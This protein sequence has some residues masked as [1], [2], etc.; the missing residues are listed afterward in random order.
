MVVLDR[1]RIANAVLAIGCRARFDGD[2]LMVS[3]TLEDGTIADLS[4]ELGPGRQYS[5][6]EFYVDLAECPRLRGLA[7][8]GPNGKMCSLDPV[9][10]CPNPERP[11]DALV[12]VLGLVIA[13]LNDSIMGRNCEDYQDEITAYWAAECSGGRAYAFD[14]PPVGTS[15]IFGAYSKGPTGALCL[16]TSQKRA[17]DFA[18]R[19][20]QSKVDAEDAFPCLLLDLSLPVQYPFPQTVSEWDAEIARSGKRASREYRNFVA[21]CTRSKAATIVLSSPAHGGRALLCFTQD[22]IESSDGFRKGEKLFEHAVSNTGYGDQR[23]VKRWAES[24]SQERLFSR[25][26][27]GAPMEGTYAIVGCGSLG[28]HL[29]RA[30]ADA[31]ASSFTVVDNDYIDAENVARHVC[32]FESVGMEKSSALKR[33]LESGNPNVTCTEYHGDVNA[34]VEERP[35]TFAGASAIF[36]TV[37]DMPTEYHMVKALMAGRIPRPLIIMW[38]EPYMLAA[39]AIVLNRPQ[40]VF[41]DLFDDEYRFTRSVVSNSDELF[42]REPGCQTTYMPYA[43]LDVQSFVIE[44]LKRWRSLTAD[45]R[46][47]Y[48]FTWVGCLSGANDVGAVVSAGHIETVDYTC[49]VERI[50]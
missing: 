10:N 38:L 34:I 40:E 13:N 4:C 19:L 1:G 17:A 32:G 18:S 39:H 20:G 46:K 47:N 33:L 44:L 31:G 6:P 43:S 7:H 11:E 30:L 36:V 21:R 22:P 3:A 9:T 28:G 8:I 49:T 23:V 41:R 45:C 27:S 48:L 14:Q 16:A 12:E 29:V 26:G 5:F 25:G 24:A 15:R 50:D 2:T 35:V 42:E 37:A